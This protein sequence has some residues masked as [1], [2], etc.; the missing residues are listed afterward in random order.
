M[1]PLQN[2]KVQALYMII[3][4]F[5]ELLQLYPYDNA[6]SLVYLGF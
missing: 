1:A 3:K 4:V 6:F 2:L 5:S